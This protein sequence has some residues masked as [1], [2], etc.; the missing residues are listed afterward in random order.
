[1][2]RQHACAVALMLGCVFATP[3]NAKPD[4]QATIGPVTQFCGDRLCPAYLSTTP[5]AIDR[6]T[7]PRPPS[8]CATGTTKASSSRRERQSGSWPRDSG[9]CGEHRH[10][11]IENMAPKMQA[12]I[13]DLMEIGYQPETDSL[14][15]SRRSRSWL[16]PLQRQRLR[17]RSTWLGQD[18]G[19]DVPR[20]CPGQTAWPSR[21][22]LVPRLGPHRRW[23]AAVASA[24]R[25]S[26]PAHRHTVVVANATRLILW[27]LKI[28]GRS[29]PRISM[30]LYVQ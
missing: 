13:A 1:M 23:F 18:G 28:R 4:P 30:S 22:R 10:H 21:W 27:S 26:Q 11:G 15:R 16:A 8:P 20:Q 9:D 25:T 14:L 7:V 5:R 17:L 2:K 3:S 29:I 12:F 6:R 19:N 24:L